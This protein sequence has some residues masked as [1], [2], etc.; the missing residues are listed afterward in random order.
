MATALLTGAY[1]LLT[2][3]PHPGVAGAEPVP[4]RRR[5]AF[6][7]GL[8]FLY[9]AEG[10]PLE[11]LANRYLLTAHMLQA[12][13]LLF[14]AP[15]LLL[16]GLPGWLLT[17]ALRPRWVRAAWSWSTRP[18]VALP[19][20]AFVFSLYL[21]PLLVESALANPWLYLLEH[22]LTVAAATLAWWPLASP[23]PDP[24]PLPC[25]VRLLYAFLIEIA[26]TAAF[27]LVTFAPAP[28]YPTYARGAATLGL[29]PLADQQIAGITMRLGSMVS[30]GVTFARAFMEWAGR[31]EKDLPL[32]TRLPDPDLPDVV[33]A[34]GQPVAAGVEGTPADWSASG[35][36]RA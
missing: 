32:R 5:V 10:S 29:A 35:S 8:V 36:P 1:L 31:G 21:L 12:V 15:P 14:W 27:A 30:F 13:L 17:P 19:L 25:P 20:F 4:A 23:L 6:V 9:L 33:P 22:S 7:L 26:M 2:G 3:S 18:V 11:L 24:P 28:L 34:Y 16:G